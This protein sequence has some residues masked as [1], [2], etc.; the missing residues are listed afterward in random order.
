MIER[1]VKKL[2]KNVAQIKLNRQDGATLN[3]HTLL[4]S[5]A[6]RATGLISRANKNKP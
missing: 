2:G 5:T 3:K 6:A 1:G 4:F